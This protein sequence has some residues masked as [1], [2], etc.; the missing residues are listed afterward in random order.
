MYYLIFCIFFF[1]CGIPHFCNFIFVEIKVTVR[2]SNLQLNHSGTEGKV[3]ANYANGLVK[4]SVSSVS[5]K[6]LM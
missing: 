2:E 6:N 4:Q 5:I 1:N 3:I